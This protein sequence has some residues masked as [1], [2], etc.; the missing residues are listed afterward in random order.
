MRIYYFQTNIRA[1]KTQH[2][3]EKGHCFDFCG[4]TLL[5]YVFYF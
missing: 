5:I 3:K 4:H 2:Q 1:G